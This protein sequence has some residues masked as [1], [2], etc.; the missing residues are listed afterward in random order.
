MP[1]S[2]AKQAKPSSPELAHPVDQL[3]DLGDR[4]AG[5]VLASGLV[6]SLVR[7]NRGKILLVTGHPLVPSL[8]SSTAAHYCGSGKR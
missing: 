3:V 4:D 1:S 8:L 2:G 6:G 7:P 5:G